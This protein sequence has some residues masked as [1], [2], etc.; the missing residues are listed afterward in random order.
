MS[1]QQALWPLME[2][3]PASHRHS[4]LTER[5]DRAKRPPSAGGQS[6]QRSPLTRS[7]P[8]SRPADMAA[9]SLNHWSIRHSL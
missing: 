1:N 9:R 8:P 7:L 6:C 3:A 2:C 5:P 4:A